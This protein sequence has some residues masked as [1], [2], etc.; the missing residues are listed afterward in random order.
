MEK[1]PL[2]HLSSL[3]G[4]VLI[5]GNTGFKGAWLTYLLLELGIQAVG[6]SKPAERDSL[7]ARAEMQGLIPEYLGDIRDRSFVQ[8]VFKETSPAVLIHMAAQPL[9][10]N[11][12]LSPHETFETNVLGTLNVIDA[13]FQTDSIKAIGV[14]TTDKVYRNNNSSLRFNEQDP[15]EGKDP[16]SASKVGTESVVAA[17][18]HISSLQS[19]PKI[20]SLRAGN[21]IGGGDFAEN[22]LIPD[23]VRAKSENK[24]LK[25]RNLE[26]SRPW[27][28]VLDP[29]WG[30]LLAVEKIL[31]GEQIKALNFGPEEESLKVREVLQIVSRNWPIEILNEPAKDT[32]EASSLELDSRAAR[33]LLKWQ[34]KFSQEEA[35]LETLAWWD[36][37]EKGKSSA[38]EQCEI[39]VR[40][41]LSS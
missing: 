16:Y 17:W 21:V 40:R 36:E 25:V 37:V 3:N 31:G 26:S 15:L 8:K 34:P 33:K 7:Y 6:L 13:A 19:G 24:P 38:K 35:I 12:Y 32:I 2:S 11:S 1:N 39:Q 9:V 23:I 27:Q 14:I 5:T 22:R 10:L 28:H 20:V 4:P 29:L 18:Q 41:Y 30:Y